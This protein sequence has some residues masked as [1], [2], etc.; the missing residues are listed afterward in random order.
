MWVGSMSEMIPIR[1]A[2]DGVHV[3]FKARAVH[4]ECNRHRRNLPITGDEIIPFSGPVIWLEGST[5]G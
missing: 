2:P 5:I 3:T 1:N 4:T